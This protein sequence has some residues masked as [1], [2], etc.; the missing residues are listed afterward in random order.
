MRLLRYAV[1]R[2]LRPRSSRRLI[3]I[4]PVVLLLVLILDLLTPLGYAVGALYVFPVLLVA[5]TRSARA[6]VLMGLLGAGLVLVGYALSPSVEQLPEFLPP[7]LNRLFSLGVIL[8]ATLM[9]LVLAHLLHR[10]RRVGRVVL[11]AQKA[12]RESLEQMDLAARMALLGAWSYQVDSNTLELSPL[13]ME[14]HGLPPGE[15]LTLESILHYYTPESRARMRACFQQCLEK[16]EGFDEQF[17]LRL[18]EGS[19]RWARCI[20]RASRDA[21]GR[22][23][24][25][26]GAFQDITRQKEIENLLLV[27]ERRFQRLVD[28]IPLIVWSA[29]PEGRVDYFSRDLHVFTGVND[30]DRLMGDGWLSVV[31]PDDRDNAAEQWQTAVKKGGNY[32][33]ELRLRRHDGRYHWHLVRAEAARDGEGL[34]RKWYGSATD[35]DDQ[36]RLQQ[37]LQQA[38]Q[39]EA[40]GHLTGGVAHDFN[41]LITVIQGNAE[42]LMAALHGD[43]RLYP[44]ADMIDGAA[45]RGAALTQRLLAVARRQ[46]L[47]PRTVDI[48][49]M[50]REMQD[51]LC[52]TLGKHVAVELQ[53][54]EGAWPARVDPSQLESALLNLCINARDAM[55]QGGRLT[56]ESDNI[57]LDLDD[58]SSDPDLVPGEYVMLAVSDTGEGMDEKT[59]AQ[60]FEPFFTTKEPG[61]GSGLGLPMLYGFI[62]QSRGHVRVD[63]SPGQGTTVRCYLPRDTEGQDQQESEM[64]VPMETRGSETVLLVEDDDLVRRYAS[65]QVQNMGYKVVEATDGSSA[66]KVLEA[67]DDIDLLFTDVVMPGGMAAQDLVVEARRLHPEIRVLYTSGYTEN[68]ILHRGRLESDGLMLSK[69]YR[70]EDLARMIRVALEQEG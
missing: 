38:Q 1:K 67:R 54:T 11:A 10:H 7:L 40:L 66:M 17:Q 61:K 24:E 3:W 22:T 45:R 26:L 14:L 60:L 52:R 34:I 59:Q 47:E 57:V 6:V 62:K 8:G 13:V 65:E 64:V 5:L 68:A 18:R 37:Q 70:R 43:Q 33:V 32:T 25:V 63:S 44:L 35:I 29:D 30:S 48:N 19:Q 28:A 55:P 69:P 20:A 23:V 9:G 4:A 27:S 56:I 49:E 39:L 36:R 21:E 31:H 53:L 2:L 41:N 51:L 16:G 50:V 58:A 12:R 46:R 15:S 42:L